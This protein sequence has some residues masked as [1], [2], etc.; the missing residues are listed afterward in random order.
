[1]KRVEH[2]E[3]QPPKEGIT[4][5]LVDTY[6]ANKPEEQPPVKYWLCMDRI[7]G[8]TRQRLVHEIKAATRAD[9]DSQLLAIAEREDV[10]LIE[11]MSGKPLCINP[12]HDS[13]YQVEEKKN[14]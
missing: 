13:P 7:V 11:E 10:T 9:A 3:L 1:M 5:T 6:I 12:A 14:G 2:L 8:E 4:Y